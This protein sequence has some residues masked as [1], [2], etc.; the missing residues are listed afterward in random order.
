MKITPVVS[1][2]LVHAGECDL[3][4]WSHL[5]HYQSWEVLNKMMKEASQ[6]Q[7][8]WVPVPAPLFTTSVLLVLKS[9][10]QMTVIIPPSS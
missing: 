6:R 1:E 5:I 10:L 8:A 2:Y 7:R 9:T 4:V 3:H